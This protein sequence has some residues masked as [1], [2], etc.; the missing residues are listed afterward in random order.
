M[1]PTTCMEPDHM[2]HTLQFKQILTKFKQVFKKFIKYFSTFKNMPIE[3]DIN[4]ILLLWEI[5]RASKS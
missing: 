5:Q 3:K 4:G 1:Y 2:Q